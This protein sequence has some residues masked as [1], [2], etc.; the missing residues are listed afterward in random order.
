MDQELPDAA[1]Y[2]P[3]ADASPDGNTS[4]REMTSWPPSWKCDVKSK[5]RL[6]QSMRISVKN[7]HATFNL[8]PIWTYEALGFFEDDRPTKNNNNN[9]TFSSDVRSVRDQKISTSTTLVKGNVENETLMMSRWWK[10]TWLEGTS[11]GT[12]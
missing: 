7:I 4:L 1:A 10:I 8:D 5:I 3:R 6:R 11:G 9:S 2:A 12:T